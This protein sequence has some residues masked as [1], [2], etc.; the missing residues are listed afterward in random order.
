M[1]VRGRVG[2]PLHKRSSRRVRQP[3]RWVPFGVRLRYARLR[4]WT[5]RHLLIR[6]A[7][8][9]GVLLVVGLTL[10]GVVAQARAVQ[11]RWG[12]VVDVVVVDRDVEFGGL[13][14]DGRFAL[15]Q[16]PELLVPEDAL[17][18]LPDDDDSVLRALSV[19]DVVT[20]RD[21]RSTRTGLV[22]PEGHRALS[23]P[24]D[25]TVP[26]V[27]AGDLVD[28]YLMARSAFGGDASQSDVIDEPAVVLDVT[29][30]A[31]VLAVAQEHMAEVARTLSDGRLLLALR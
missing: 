7:V 9:G 22:M 11:A 21:L 10:Y 19:G 16:T 5:V 1:S 4:A 2:E 23:V 29:G 17:R 26:H 27:V 14:S 24:I 15:R 8:C 31:V 20:E 18:V 3:R 6:R 30:E 13:V 25:P 12:T 28:V